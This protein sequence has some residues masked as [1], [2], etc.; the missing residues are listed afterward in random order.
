MYRY[1]EQANTYV[2]FKGFYRE[3][4]NPDELEPLYARIGQPGT[5]RDS[6]F[7]IQI[8]HTRDSYPEIL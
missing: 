3:A 8:P 6:K 4:D 7:Q 5:D 1:S 2:D